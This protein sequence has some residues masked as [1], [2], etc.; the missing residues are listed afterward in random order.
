MEVVVARV[1]EVKQTNDLVPVLL[2]VEVAHLDTR[3]EIVVEG[4]VALLQRTAL[5][6]RNLEDGLIDCGGGEPLVDS[7]QSVGQYVGQEH[8]AIVI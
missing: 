1:V 6:V 8:I 2:T 5:D 3:L 7:C 4:L